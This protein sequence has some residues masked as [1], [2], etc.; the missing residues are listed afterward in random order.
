MQ[1]QQHDS[2]SAPPTE[3]DRFLAATA[4]MDSSYDTTQRSSLH[5]EAPH[6]R[7]GDADGSI[8]ED[9][10]LAAQAGSSS[11]RRKRTLITAA[12]LLALVC[13]VALIVPLAILLPKRQPAPT[14]VLTLKASPSSL[15][16]TTSDADG[17]AS[18]ANVPPAPT[19]A[20]P[21]SVVVSG[22]NQGGYE[23]YRG[24]CMESVHQALQ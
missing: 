18:T 20:P 24:E 16:P 3:T 13:V 2:V 12:V 11:R 10:V 21:V 5:D 6:Q 4:T 8:N 17:E 23:E 14:V 22:V 19:A 15:P 7:E 1:H 9:K